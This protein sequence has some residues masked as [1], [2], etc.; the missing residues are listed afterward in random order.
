MIARIT[1]RGNGL[2]DVGDYVPGNDGE[3]YRVLALSGAIQTGGPGGGNWIRATVELADW[4][5]CAEGEES[6]C[7]A[8][9]DAEDEEV[10]S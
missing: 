10:V 4:S 6:T 2:V 7:L 3:L 1:E 8:T 9:V 5:D